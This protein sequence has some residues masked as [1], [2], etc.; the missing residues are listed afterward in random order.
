MV[1]GIAQSS[2]G[3]IN[4]NKLSINILLKSISGLP[5]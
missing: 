4:N 1:T 5:V 3:V 2:E